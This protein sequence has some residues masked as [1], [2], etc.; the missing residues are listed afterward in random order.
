MKE[1]SLTGIQNSVVYKVLGF[2]LPPQEFQNQLTSLSP[3]IYESLRGVCTRLAFIN[4][5]E[6]GRQVIDWNIQE[7]VLSNQFERLK[8]YLTITCIDAITGIHFE[9]FHEWLNLEYKNKS[10]QNSKIWKAAIQDLTD[11][12]ESEQTENLLL[13]HINN[14]YTHDYLD[15]TSKRRAIKNFVKDSDSWLKDWICNLYLIHYLEQANAQ[16]TTEQWVD[17][18][19]DKKS[20][21]IAEYLYRTRNLYTH[22]V[23]GYEPLNFA[24]RS[25]KNDINGYIAILLPSSLH[26]E[27]TMQISLPIEYGETEVIRLLIIRWMRKN[28][29][30]ID[31]DKSFIQQYWQAV[32][33][34]D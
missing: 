7:H 10:I 15:A 2:A 24:Q 23:I 27:K 33:L 22:T 25:S 11:S 13:K 21:R 26:S 1:Q 30:K 34:Q 17:M 29:L 4:Q 19:Q 12:Q 28:W 31:D 20:E 5:V 32:S 6:K 3:E 14:I 18:S 9:Q 8:L 16:T